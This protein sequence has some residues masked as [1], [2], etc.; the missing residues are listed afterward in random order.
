[1]K[2]FYQQRM[3]NFIITMKPAAYQEAIDAF[4]D[5]FHRFEA[6][7]ITT[8]LINQSWKITCQQ[9]GEIY[10]LQ[11]IN[12]TVFPDPELLQYNYELLWKHIRATRLSFTIPAPKYFAGETT[13]YTDSNNRCWRVFEFVPGSVTLSNIENPQ[14]AKTVATTFAAFTAGFANFDAAQLHP[15]IYRFHDLS[16]RFDQFKESLHSPYYERLHQAALLIEELKKREYYSSFYDIITESGEFR[17]RVMHHDAKISNILFDNTGKVICP[18]DLDTTMPG[19]FFSDLGDMI[20]SMAGSHD[21]KTKGV[22]HLHIRKE[23]YEAIMNGYLS[24]MENQLTAAEKKYI[25][26]AGPAMICMQALRFLSDYLNG[27]IYYRIDY[28]EQNYDR[29][30]NQL[31][32]LLKL[33]EFLEKQYAFRI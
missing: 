27:D 15:T 32:L 9:T 23:F 20:R 25:H 31:T 3:A 29:A 14:Q 19:Y 22:D 12:T 16:F 26:F 6:E 7:P 13:F 11:Q 17:L 24:V 2:I 8:G 21:E 10:L 5:T 4:A 1:M 28:P 30:K 18:V 33:E